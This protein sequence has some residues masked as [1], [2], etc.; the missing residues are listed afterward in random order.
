MPS[1]LAPDLFSGRVAIVTGGGAGLGRATAVRFA[2]LGAHVVVAG[3]TAVPGEETV[4]EINAAGAE[5]LFV[6]CDV[7]DPADVERLVA[8]TVKRFG[9]LDFAYNNAGVS[10]QPA[11][12]D[13]L[14]E[15]EWDRVIGINLTGVFLCMKYELRQLVAQ[16]EGGA[17]VNASSAAGM[18]AFNRISAYT[19]SKFAVIGLSREVARDY[20]TSGIRVNVVSPS[21]ID[22]PMLRA[23]PDTA[24]RLR[25]GTPIGRLGEATEVAEAVVWLCSDGAS[26]VTGAVLPVDGAMTA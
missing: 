7:A 13:D 21:T 18:K 10:Q 3:R 12:L 20:G 4:A 23:N 26:Y 8:S 14:D 11:L 19:A 15:D 5:G 9:R 22:S 2:E 16:G 17:I 1:N 6:Q 24:E 25:H